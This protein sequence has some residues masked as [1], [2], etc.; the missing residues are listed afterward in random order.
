MR[1]PRWTRPLLLT[2]A[3][4]L[5]CAGGKRKKAAEPANVEPPVEVQRPP[6]PT[7]GALF[8]TGLPV[9]PG[10]TP[11][12]LAN[13]SAQGC[14]A[15]HGATHDA[16]RS[17]AHAA[18][19]SPTFLEATA[20]TPECRVCHLPLS[21][22]H[23]TLFTPGEPHA[24]RPPNARFD[25]TLATEGVTCAACH[26][27]EGHVIGGT[28]PARA[29]HPGRFTT[30]LGTSE[31]C[32]TCHQ[33]TWPG[34]DTPLYDTYGEWSRSPHAGADIGCV[35]CHMGPD[36]GHSAA[37]DHRFP[38]DPRRALSVLIETDRL[39]IA[40]G[41]DALDV[42]IR[43]QNTGAGHSVPTGS[44]F[45]GL[46]VV[47]AL[48]CATDDGP[49]RHAELAVDLHRRLGEAAPWPTI[50]DTRLQAGG[51]R[52]IPWTPSLG[53]DAPSGTWHLEVAL[54]HTQVPLGA[55]PM[56]IDPPLSVSVLP[57]QVD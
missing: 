35:D 2:S 25:A 33:L 55:A 45:R 42:T 30:D 39:D 41:G 1:F 47:A 16:W 10:P 3:L 21:D 44:P 5:L 27:R 6:A 17:S 11:R 19:M 14:N 13:R 20:G 29:P 23:A 51:E 49:H 46:R 32:A 40:R 4:A 52:H 37:P 50:E 7:H 53:L 22:Q 36:A 18:P 56:Q 34:A 28:P 54:H 31:A 9:D 8:P 43:L 48:V 12:G 57:L 24:E 38:A 15:C 26:L